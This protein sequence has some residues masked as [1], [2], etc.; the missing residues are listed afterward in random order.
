MSRDDEAPE[1]AL[2][3]TYEAEFHVHTI[4]TR[5]LVNGNKIHIVIEG[6]FTNEALSG[7]SPMF[8]KDCKVRFK[9]LVTKKTRKKLG[10]EDSLP[11][12]MDEGVGPA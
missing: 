1:K 5:K 8:D 12:P 2:L 9:E 3:A 11:L 4:G 10:D 7:M 6:E